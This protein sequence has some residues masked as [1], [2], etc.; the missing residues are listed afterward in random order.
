[1]PGLVVVVPVV[2]VMWWNG[3]AS[4]FRFGLTA[5]PSS[6]IAATAGQRKRRNHPA[7]SLAR[8]LECSTIERSLSS[9]LVVPAVAMLAMVVFV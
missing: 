3:M 7:V 4:C 6:G 1:M 2:V 8:K 5:Q 9:S